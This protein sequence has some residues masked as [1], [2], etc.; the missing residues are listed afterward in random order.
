MT[1]KYRTTGKVAFVSTQIER[2]SP[3]DAH[4]AF[5]TRLLERF[6]DEFNQ[7]LYPKVKGVGELPLSPKQRTFC[8]K[9]KELLFATGGNTVM[10]RRIA[11]MMYHGCYMGWLDVVDEPEIGERVF[12]AK[13]DDRLTHCFKVGPDG[14]LLVAIATQGVKSSGSPCEGPTGQA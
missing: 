8:H 4:S 7:G 5:I 2:A 9:Q 11:A 6:A 12:V 1:S 14:G 13:D 10:T 3:G